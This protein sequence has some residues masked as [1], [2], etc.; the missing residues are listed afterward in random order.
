M[1]FQ[2]K[3]IRTFLFLVFVVLLTLH[4]EAQKNNEQPSFKKFPIIVGMQYHNFA[5]PFW[6]LLGN[7]NHPGLTIGSEIPFNKRESLLQQVSVGGY[8]NREI[9]N[10]IYVS[11][12][13]V[14]RP[15]LIHN[16]FGEIKAGISYLRTYHPSQAYEFTNGDWKETV[17]GKSQL[18]IPFDVGIGFTTTTDFAKLSPFVSY[19]VVPALF[20]NKTLPI[21]L[22]TNIIFGLRI[23]LIG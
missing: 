4:T 11:S 19:Q 8:L 1:I 2:F 12:Q 3:F 17:G 21:S 14:Y 18:G 6:D 15:K 23:K 7:F 20:Y 10:G 16:F 5:L 9:G 13:L 22:Y